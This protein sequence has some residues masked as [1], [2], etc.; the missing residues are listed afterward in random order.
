VD[1]PQRPFLALGLRILSAF[2]FATLQMLVMFAGESGVALPEIMSWRAVS[3]PI[4]LAYLAE[5]GGLGRLRTWRLANHGRRAVL[6][7]TNRIFNFG[8]TILLLLAMSTVLGFTSPLFAV[9]LAALW[10]REHVGPYL[11][12]AVALGFLGVLVI[13]DPA[14]SPSRS[15][16]RWRCSVRCSSW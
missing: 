11:W 12:T 1:L 16:R 15:A 8:A 3:L 13:A 2:F 5:T 7:M 10:M 14:P 4:L 6:G 9:L